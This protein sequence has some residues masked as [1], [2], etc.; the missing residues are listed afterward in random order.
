MFLNARGPVAPNRFHDCQSTGIA[1]DRLG[2][3]VTGLP[4]EPLT[5]RRRLA[6]RIEQRH[7][8]AEPLTDHRECDRRTAAERRRIDNVIV[9][10][11]E[12]RKEPRLAATGHEVIADNRDALIDPLYR[13]RSHALNFCLRD[14]S[15][16]RPRSFNFDGFTR[17]TSLRL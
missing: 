14:V 6:L 11:H 5:W 10:A 8:H 9:S 7:A 15:A 3:T 1:L 12:R 4:H 2:T 13:V 16:A 17:R